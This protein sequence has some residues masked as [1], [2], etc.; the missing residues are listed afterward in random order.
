MFQKRFS[1][2]DEIN[3][4]TLCFTN[5]DESFRFPI[6][7][8]SGIQL[9]ISRKTNIWENKEK[10]HQLST[11]PTSFASPHSHQS[12]LVWGKKVIKVGCMSQLWMPFICK[13]WMLI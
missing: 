3:R 5:V 12:E 9:V 7:G 1:Q 8:E 13:Q 2:A 4:L 10:K 11:I 6:G